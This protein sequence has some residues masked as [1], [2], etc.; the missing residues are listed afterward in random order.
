VVTLAV[1]GGAG[2]VGVDRTSVA[3][4]ATGISASGAKSAVLLSSSTL[5]G[6]TLGI[7]AAGG[8]ATISYKTNNINL[9]NVTDGAP[10]TSTSQN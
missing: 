7:T 4:N 3:S 10:T 2:V 1:G 9:G 5:L 6:N 8:A